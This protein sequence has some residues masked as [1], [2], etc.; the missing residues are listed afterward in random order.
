MFF[1][2]VDRGHDLTIQ[3]NVFFLMNHAHLYLLSPKTNFGLLRSSN[4]S[5]IPRFRRKWGARAFAVAAP[6]TC[7]HVLILR[8]SCA[9]FM[10]HG[11]SDCALDPDHNPDQPQIFKGLFSDPKHKSLKIKQIMDPDR[12]IPKI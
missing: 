4:R 6:F 5:T 11:R 7:N 1:T 9:Q 10:S 2:D 8:R 3:K 12:I